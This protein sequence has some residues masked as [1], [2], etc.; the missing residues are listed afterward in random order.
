MNEFSHRCGHSPCEASANYMFGK[1]NPLGNNN[2]PPSVCLLLNSLLS[3]VPQN[4]AKISL[5]L[6]RES[7][8]GHRARPSRSL[9]ASP[10]WWF[11]VVHQQ[12]QATLKNQRREVW[13][14]HNKVEGFSRQLE[15]FEPKNCYV[16]VL[17]YH[18]R[19]DIF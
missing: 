16:L 14:P 5:V 9:P 2:L 7:W 11:F 4:N 6:G 17:L 8:K 3:P 13:Y 15:R 10:I 12:S 1:E 19:V 18:S